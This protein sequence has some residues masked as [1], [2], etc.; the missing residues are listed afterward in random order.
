MRIWVEW[1]GRGVEKDMS[2]LEGEGEEEL[3]HY[4]NNLLHSRKNHLFNLVHE[5][6]ETTKSEPKINRN[7]A[8]VQKKKKKKKY[9]RYY[10]TTIS[11]SWS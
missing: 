11:Y 3:H 5:T 10:L 7:I 8:S 9:K 4:V 6:I 2:G 1:L